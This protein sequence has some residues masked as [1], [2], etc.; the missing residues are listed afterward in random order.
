MTIAAPESPPEP[1]SL[2]RLLRPCARPALWLL[3]VFV[4]PVATASL[5]TNPFDPLPPP[6][7]LIPNR[8]DLWLDLRSF[9]PTPANLIK[10][11]WPLPPVLIPFYAAPRLRIL[12]SRWI[13]AGIGPRF[14]Y[15]LLRPTYFILACLLT[16]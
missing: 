14:A 7:S 1:M 13:P 6:A 8:F 16:N 2:A 12:S 15:R 10:I 11:F 4:L 9:G 3:H 5:I